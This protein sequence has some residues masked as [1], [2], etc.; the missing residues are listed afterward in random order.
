MEP[1]QSGVTVRVVPDAAAM[2]RTTAEIVVETVR[3]LPE[4]VIAF[5]T[6]STPLGLFADLIA[7]VEAGTL[8]L[9][10]IRV[11]CLDDYLGVGP[12]DP[13]SL[14]RWLRDAFLEPARLDLSRVQMMPAASPDPVAAAA[15]YE[16][17]LADVGGLDLAILGLGPNGHI[18]YNEPG[19]TADSRTRV[20][21]LTPSSTEQASAYW[22]DT[23][24]I[25]SRA[26]TIGVA[27]LLAARR[28]VLMVGGEAKSEVLRR[29]LQKPMTADL[30]AS[31]LQ[32]A[33]DRL[34]VIADQAAAS[35]L[36][37]PTSGPRAIDE[38]RAGRQRQSPPSV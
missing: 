10:R 2:S 12:D 15:N 35:K 11:F 37:E 9:S 25:S 5:P 38:G 22:H 28:I 1:E 30:P 31:W 36:D 17:A 13:N 23:L 18:A 24:P 19:A 4:A 34:E 8:D 20:V 14:T 3:R 16:T 21:D 29:A 6:G 32:S 33:G 27:T 26:M 7:R